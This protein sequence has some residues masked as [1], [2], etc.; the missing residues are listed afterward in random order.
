[1]VS[2]VFQGT[3][4]LGGGGLQDLEGFSCHCSRSEPIRTLR[5]RFIRATA[6][7][8]LQQGRGLIK[9]CSMEPES[10]R[11]GPVLGCLISQETRK[12]VGA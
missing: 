10:L 2:I 7:V 5:S 4:N 12:G 6:F 11:V 9:G 1:M 3:V 8:S